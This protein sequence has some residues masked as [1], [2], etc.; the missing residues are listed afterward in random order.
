MFNY[1]FE[2]AVNFAQSVYL[3][4]FF[5]AFLG[6][7]YSRKRN[8]AMGSLFIVLNFTVLTYFTFNNPYVVM[9]D[10]LTVV[11]LHEVYCLTCLKGELAIKIILPLVA[12]LI[13]TI[14]S[15]GVLYLTSFVT[16]LSLEELGLQSSFFRYLCVVLVNLTIFV[17]LLLMWRTKAKVY[18]LKKVS[19]IIAFIAIPVLAMAILYITFYIMILTNYQSNLIMLLSIICISMV[20]IA[21]MVW[22]MIAR[23][24]RDNQIA[25]KLLLSEQRANLYENNIINS[26]KQIENTVRIR[27]DMKNNIACIDNL[28]L[29]GKYDEAH[30]ICQKVTNKFSS[31]GTIVNTDNSLLNAVLNVEI[32]KARL[33]GISVKLKISDNM[34]QFNN[35]SD[36]ISIIGNIFDNAI[37]YLTNHE[38]KNKEIIFS[39][40]RTGFY[41]IIKCN[42][43]II[44][45]VLSK[46]PLLQT[47]KK[48]KRN[49]GKGISIV[50]SIAQKYGGDVVIS[51][52]NN[53]FIVSVILDNR[54]FT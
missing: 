44:E 53:E 31:G 10:M 38:T 19:N 35:E 37:S 16:G 7:K 8:I 41:S 42:N 9:I 21:V 47:D 4:G 13:N 43:K 17:T 14:I 30:K 52:K 28:I 29:K 1:G 54:I 15:Y 27:H 20:V 12:S 18:S 26:N 32:E 25:I 34:K 3:I 45:S 40:E 50:K 2:L 36:I 11:I 51:E 5:L 46:N 49:H 23:I 22:F 48:N 33:H 24:N 6:G 39:I